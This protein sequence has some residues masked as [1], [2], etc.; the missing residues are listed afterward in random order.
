MAYMFGLQYSNKDFDNPKAFG[1]NTFTT[2][3]PVSLSLYI[4]SKGLS[5]NYIYAGLDEHGSPTIRHGL[6]PLPALLGIDPEKA[7]YMFEESYQGYD[8]YALNAADRSD[9]VVR[10]RETEKELAALEVKLVAVPTSGTAHCPRDQQLCELV[11]RPPSIEQLCFSV[12]ASFGEKRRNDINNAIV[13][14]LVNPMDFKWQDE[15]YMFNKRSEV[16]DAA[17]ELIH[18]GIDSQKPFALMGEWRTVDQ[19]PTLDRECFDC[20]YWSNMAFLQLFVR[21]MQ[22]SIKRKATKPKI[23][24]PERSLIWFIKSMFDYSAQGRVMFEKTH[25]EIVY[26]GQTDKAGSFTNQ[27]IAPFVRTN[28][29]VHPRIERDEREKIISNE[30]LE[31]L[32]PERR[33]DTTLVMD[34]LI[35]E[36]AVERI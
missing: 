36:Q 24:R 13:S 32:M 21:A 28:N 7:S 3:F 11:V 22:R 18:A 19:S 1:K 29:F 31:L 15:S 12:A 17:N 14:A 23:G 6:A 16:L 25:S 10:D 33:L 26:G 4:H 20:F 8:A 34:Y 9:V 2:A 5:Q 27:S 35:S 30:G